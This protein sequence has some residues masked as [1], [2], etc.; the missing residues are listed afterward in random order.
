MPTDE[1]RRDPNRTAIPFFCVDAVCEV[2][3]GSYPGNMPGEYFSD[4]AHIRQWL[5]VERDLTAFRAFLDEYIHGVPDFHGYLQKCGG[6][7]R[8]QEL[9]RQEFLL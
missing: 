7:P 1:F 8:M 4:E 9:R 2:P 5:D 3:F 6:L